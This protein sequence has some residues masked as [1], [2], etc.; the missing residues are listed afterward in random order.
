MLSLNERENK[1]TTR[2]SGI[3]YRF[4]LILTL[5]DLIAGKYNEERSQ[6]HIA[7]PH[8]VCE[9]GFCNHINIQYRENTRRNSDFTVIQPFL[10][11]STPVMRYLF[12]HPTIHTKPNPAFLLTYPQPPSPEVPTIQASIACP[13]RTTGPFFLFSPTVDRS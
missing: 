7:L 2:I 8:H 9:L 11:A 10:Q 12:R 5:D 6:L 3:S 1:P 13:I 4:I